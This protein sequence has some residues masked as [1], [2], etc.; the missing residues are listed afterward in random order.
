MNFFLWAYIILPAPQN[1]YRIR[2]LF[3]L[4]LVKCKL[5]H[6]DARVQTG[7]KHQLPPPH[8]TIKNVDKATYTIMGLFQQ[9]VPDVL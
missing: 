5:L 1:T 9:C 3:A 7:S 4:F 6:K 2:K 8:L